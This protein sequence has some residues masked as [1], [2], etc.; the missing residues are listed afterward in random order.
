MAASG[1]RTAKSESRIDPTVSPVETTGLPKPPVV[2]A[3]AA[4]VITV[5]PWMTPEDPPPKIAA[6]LHFRKGVIS[7]RTEAV[8]KVPAMTAAGVAEA[9]SILSTQGM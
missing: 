6:M 8:M 2:K 1:R 9:S 7:G 3:D 5:A 4:L